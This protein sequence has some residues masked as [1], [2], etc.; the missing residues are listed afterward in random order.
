MASSASS[1]LQTTASPSSTSPPAASSSPAD[2]ESSDDGPTSKPLLFFVALGFGVVFTNLW[3]IVGVKYCFRYNQ[4]AR[5]GML[6]DENG[7]QIGMDTMHRPRRR[8]EKKLMSMDEVNERFPLTKY[9]V[10]RAGRENEGLPTS[11][12]IATNTSRPSSVRNVENTAL[13][14]MSTEEGRGGKSSETA[15]DQTQP[16]ATEEGVQSTDFAEMSSPGNANPTAKDQTQPDEEKSTQPSDQPSAQQMD[17]SSA[18]KT[19]HSTAE[20]PD[21]KTVNSNDQAADEDDDDPIRTALPAEV[22]Q[23][24]PGDTCAICIDNLDED[25]EVRGLTCGHAFHVGCVDPWLTSRRAC[26]PLCKADY[27]VPKDRRDSNDGSGDPGDGN[28][29]PNQPRPLYTRGMGR[30]GPPFRPTI[31]FGQRFTYERDRFGIPMFSVHRNRMN[32]NTNTTTPVQHQREPRSRQVVTWVRTLPSHLPS[33]NWS[34]TSSRREGE[35]GENREAN[36]TTPNQL[37]AGTR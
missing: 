26:C 5:Q 30:V 3:I 14:R 11:G 10:W 19:R 13:K 28:N 22:V 37:E 15:R 8:R 18:D 21:L 6:N 27:Y 1:T 31:I 12:G 33:F 17:G 25:D 16:A 23:A 4:R 34:R 24:S 9:K 35:Q 20:R 36:A 29:L 32:E 2:S 7:D